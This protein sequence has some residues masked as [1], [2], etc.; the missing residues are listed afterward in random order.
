MQFSRQDSVYS[1]ISYFPTP[2][3]GDSPTVCSAAGQIFL[4]IMKEAIPTVWYILCHRERF[5][6][7]VL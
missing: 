1:K 3:L 6:V 5:T 2:P 4:T 7:K